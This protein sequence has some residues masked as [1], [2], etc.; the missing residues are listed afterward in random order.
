VL[1]GTH[2]YIFHVFQYCLTNS[3]SKDE[4]GYKEINCKSL[5][6]LYSLRIIRATRCI[7]DR[8]TR[9]DSYCARIE[10]H[11][12][13]EVK[14]SRERNVFHTLRFS[15]ATP[16]DQCPTT[17]NVAAIKLL[18]GLGRNQNSVTTDARFS[19]PHAGQSSGSVYAARSYRLY[20]KTQA[21]RI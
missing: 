12:T 4:H 2:P 21:Y 9:E 19:Q 10:R 14:M 16:V 5:L 7:G 11:F 3:R 6:Q 13:R 8:M 17:G 15:R 18:I 1:V 20:C